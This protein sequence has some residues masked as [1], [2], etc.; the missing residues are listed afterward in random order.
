MDAETQEKIYLVYK[1][2][3]SPHDLLVQEMRAMNPDLLSQFHRKLMK[4]LHPDK[5]SHPRAKEAFHN[6]QEAIKAVKAMSPNSS[7]QSQKYG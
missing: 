6:V 1:Y 7:G 2:L 3:E 5:N 4:Q